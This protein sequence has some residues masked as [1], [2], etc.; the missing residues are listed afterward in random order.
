MNKSKMLVRFGAIMLFANF[1]AAGY[2]RMANDNENAIMFL[3]GCAVWAI[4]ITIHQVNAD[5]E[6]LEENGHE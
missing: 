6:L 5:A 1:V 4:G 3:V 2:F